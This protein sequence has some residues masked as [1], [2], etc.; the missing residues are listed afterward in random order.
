M[1]ATLARAAGV[2]AAL[3]LAAGLAQA[4]A[5][6]DAFVDI[7]GAAATDGF[8]DLTSSRLGA[9]ATGTSKLVA[10]IASNVAGSDGGA[11]LKRLSG[12]YY[13]ASFGLYSYS[14]DSAFGINVASA[15]AALSSVTLQSF[16]S[17][18]TSQG[19][20]G[21]S[22]AAYL[23]TLSYNGG[24]QRL[25]AVYTLTPVSGGYDIDGTPLTANPNNPNYG[26]FSWDLSSVTTPIT[27]FNVNFGI[28]QHAN[29]L[30]FQ[31]DQVAAV[32]EP[33]SYAFAALGLAACGWGAW[34][35]RQARAVPEGAGT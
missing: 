31:L 27:S 9:G 2:A 5:T 34:R 3:S 29:V 25:A 8:N 21:L 16:V 6:Y 11:V 35:R 12:T 18:D 15:V 1:S 22:S 13:P 19:V 26:V 32:P 17:V 23:P 24:T 28:T 7:A 30:A 33:G 14:S 20:T 10:G 4:N